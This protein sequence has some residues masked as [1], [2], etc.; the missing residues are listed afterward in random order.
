M[1]V[2]P[3]EVMMGDGSVLCSKVNTERN[4]KTRQELTSMIS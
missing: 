2:I 3:G 4:G 1:K